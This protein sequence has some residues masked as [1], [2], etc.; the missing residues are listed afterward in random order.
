MRIRFLVPVFLVVALC[1]SGVFAATP[2]S[3]Q[4]KASSAAKSKT[5]PKSKTKKSKKKKKVS[6][7]RIRRMRRAFVASTELKPMA[8]QLLDSRSRAAYAGVEAYGRKHAHDDAGMLANLALGYAHILDHEPAQA[9]PPLRAA[10]ARAGDLSDY[11]VYFLGS[12]CQAAG[13]TEAALQTLRGFESRFPDSIFLRD[14]VVVYGN[15]LVTSGRAPEAVP[16]L[17]NNRLPTRSDLELALGRALLRAGDAARGADVLRHIYYSMPLA[18]EAAEAGALLRAAGGLG[19]NFALEKARADQIAQARRFRDAAQEYRELLKMASAEDRPSVEVALAGA[20]HRSGDDRQAR[21]ILEHVAPASAELNAERLFYLLEIARSDRDDGRLASILSQLRQAAPASTWLE[22]GLLTAGNMLLLRNDYDP[23]I[24]AYR[25]IHQRFGQGR[26]GAYAHWKVAWLSLRQG[27]V[28][29]ARRGFE[30]QIALYPTSPQVPAALYWR[31]RLAEEEHG[32][33]RARAYYEK[34]TQRFRNYYYAELARERLREL[35]AQAAD[36]DPLLDKIPPLRISNNFGDTEPPADDLRAQKARL[37]G[38]GGLTEF[39]IR[40]LKMAAQE[41]GSAWATIE[42]ARLYRQNEQYHRALELLKRTVP[43]YF[44]LELEAL[45]RP[46]WEDLFPRP[47]WTDVKHYAGANQLDPFL[48][49]SL[50]RQ[51]SEFNPAAISGANALGLMQLLPSTGR[52]LAREMKVRRY[53]NQQLLTPKLNLQLGTRYF[54]ELVD[55]FNGRLE[56]ALAAYN[57]G[58]DRVESWLAAGNFRDPQEFVESIPFTETREYVQAIL[59][60]AVVYRQL[61]GKP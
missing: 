51:E 20:L 4:K 30:E 18:G 52:K 40:E 60:N 26:F 23:A 32:A 29:A 41:D 54:R 17:Q 37:L 6:A 42:M 56:Y 16:I 33:P 35:Q 7:V 11:A 15:A 59:R 57:A 2:K 1:V 31:A 46:Y 38:N 43:A 50:I 53:S 34:L 28:E 25:E 39:A 3:S 36:P 19:G 14:A 61:Y 27:R 21:D 55:H 44:S 5:R 24:D 49:A 58:S 48:V 47:W 12:A 45:P 10:Q 9:I 8:R 13:E 22:Q